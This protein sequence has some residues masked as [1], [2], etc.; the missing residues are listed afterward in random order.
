[1]EIGFRPADERDYEACRRLYFSAMEKTIREF[2]LDPAAHAEGFREQWIAAQVRIIQA[3][4]EDV[5]WMQVIDR[6]DDLFLAQIFLKPEF[7]NRGIGTFA[8]QCVMREAADRGQ[9]LAL[10]VIK[11]NPA[12]GLYKRL[13]FRVT[14]EDE[15]K[16]YMRLDPPSP[17]RANA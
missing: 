2:G 13:G 15:F 5:G 12:L 16:F 6:L 9:P 14:H 11:S 10:A 17:S 3:E 1:M 7:Q 8:L 4:R